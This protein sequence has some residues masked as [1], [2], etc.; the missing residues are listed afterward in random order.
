MSEAVIEKKGHP[1]GFWLVSTLQIFERFNYYG[2]RGLLM[3][4]LTTTAIQGGLGLDTV[5]AATIY[6]TF[7]MSAYFAPLLGGYISD[8]FL[9]KRSTFFIGSIF[10]AI[11]TFMLFM[12]NTKTM[13]YGSLMC[14]VIGNGLWKPNITSIVGDFYD[15][16]DPRK[17]GAYSIFYTFIN[18]GALLA[19][20]ICGTVAEKIFAKTNGTEVISYGYKYGFLTASI[21]MLIGTVIYILFGKKYLG[22][23]GKYDASK[24]QAKN[25]DLNKSEKQPLTK[26]EKKR[27]F[28]ICALSFFVIIFWAAFEQAGSSLTMYTH[29]YI[30]RNVGGFEVPTSWF[31]SINPFLCI[32]LGPIFAMWFIKLSKR[33]KGDIPTATKMGYGLIILGIGFGL[34]A[35]A[36]LERGNSTDIAVK[37]NILW[38]FG[39]Y[40][41]HTVGEMFL[42][43]VGLSMVSKLAP[44]Q[45]AAIM[46]GVWLFATGVGNYIAGMS[47]AFVESWGGLQ[48]FG[49]VTVITIGS[50]IILCLLSPIFQKIMVL[51][52]E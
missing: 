2:M 38:L 31:Q 36:A 41:M 7:T 42:S 8:T 37:A 40:T 25:K 39:A 34:M 21:G 5:T 46:M 13:L 33:E 44:K 18:I 32:V 52:N 1:A 50:G 28:A 29:D 20:F 49:L 17:D 3:L 43:P 22:D 35:G 23:V 27:V 4:F 24:K 9:G 11:G 15:N 12:T 10:I 26:D 6:S 51:D 48:V 14:I 47:A 45:I 16:N 19:P 30:N